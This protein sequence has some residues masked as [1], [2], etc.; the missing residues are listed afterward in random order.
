MNLHQVLIGPLVTEKSVRLQELNKHTF[1]VHKDATK[2][3]V[4]NAIRTYY[5][6]TP[7]SVRILTNPKK[8]RSGGKGRSITKRKETRRA[9]VSIQMGKSLE[10]MSVKKSS[11]KK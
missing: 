4:V 7:L 2:I 3:D 9:I 6:I 8:G 1:R 10:L 5:G 11:S